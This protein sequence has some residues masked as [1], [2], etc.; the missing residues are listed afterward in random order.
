MQVQNRGSFF[1][2]SSPSQQGYE[3]V[4]SQHT[5]TQDMSSHIEYGVHT[6]RVTAS[7]LQVQCFIEPS[8][9]CG[10]TLKAIAL[11]EGQCLCCTAE[12][13]MAP[14]T[15]HDA[16]LKCENQ[17]RAGGVIIDEQPQNENLPEHVR[18]WLLTARSQDR[19]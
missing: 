6:Q 11:S 8:A 4:C 17:R 16:V 18:G 19:N 5:H 10:V 2:P 14:L 7:M 15:H 1:L 12:G 3:A 9:H 13:I